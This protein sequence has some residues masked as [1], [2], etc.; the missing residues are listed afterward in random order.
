MPTAIRIEHVSKQYR[1]G[2]FTSGTLSQDLERWW[3]LTRGRPDPFLIVDEENDQSRK[4]GSNVVWSLKDVHLDIE[5]GSA[6][7]VVGRNGA[8][9]STLLKILSRITSPT[10]GTVRMR[11]SFASLLE[12]GTGFHPELTGRENIF[13]NG[14][15]LGMRKAEIARRFDEIV[16]FAGVERYIDTPVKR[17]SSGM[18][19][20]LAFAVAAHFDSEI[21]LV[22]EVLA[23][24]DAE[25]QK[26]CLGK[27]SRESRS[28]GRT[29]LFVSHNHHAVRQLCTSAIH[30]ERGRVKDFGPADRILRA[31]MRLE[32][33]EAYAVVFPEEIHHGTDA[34]RID[35]I[36]ILDESLEPASS[37][38]ISRPYLF[39]IAYTVRKPVQVKL[40]FILSSEDGSELFGSL[41]N[42]EPNFYDREQEPGR[43][44]SL[45]R[46][47]GDL[48]NAGRFTVSLNSFIP[49]HENFAALNLLVFEAVD[50]GVLKGD[51][52]GGFGGYLRPRL[53][54]TTLRA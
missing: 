40:S 37:Y 13:L 34:I 33:A 27:M 17:Y 51:F 24:G 54:W 52:M 35:S 3:A 42:H 26:K 15:I 10:T 36:R 6:V 47:P 32:Q 7:G 43:Y 23:V 4:G 22:D 31:Y 28:A 14:A 20:R 44:R 45:V 19:V 50:D 9:K 25:F 49:Y 29:I 38:Q 39:E 46:V 30:L 12:V 16:D 53:Q 48:L 8:G 5:R 21:L 2:Q 11:G 1:L 18:Y 41:N